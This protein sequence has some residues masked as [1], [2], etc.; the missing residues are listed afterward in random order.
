MS[1]KQKPVV[2]SP[3]S[4]ISMG[5]GRGSKRE[6]PAFASVSVIRNPNMS[7]IRLFGMDNDCKPMIIEIK[8]V[9]EYTDGVVRFASP[10]RVV[11]ALQMSEI[12]WARLASGSGCVDA[13]IEYGPTADSVIER[14][15]RIDDS[16]TLLD[17][18]TKIAADRVIEAVEACS[19]AI[20]QLN[21]LIESGKANKGQ[22]IDIRDKI[23]TVK[24]APMHIDYL[25]E[26]LSKTVEG[27]R[28]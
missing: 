3:K 6:H 14:K 21:T 11:L 28:L 8:E 22:L 20:Q 2:T 12:Q 5:I 4:P 7:D 23:S 19:G 15:P 13:T 26:V 1:E 16:S 18:S 17:A 10:K 9:E 25:R 27:S 24:A